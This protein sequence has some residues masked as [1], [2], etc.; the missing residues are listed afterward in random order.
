MQQATAQG[1]YMQA[2][3][4]GMMMQPP[5]GMDPNAGGYPMDAGEYHGLPAAL[6]AQYPALAT[7]NWS[8]PVMG[9]GSGM[10]DDLSGRSSFDASDYDEADD[11][12]Y[13]SGSGT[14][15]GQGG[16]NEGFGEMGYTS[17]YGGP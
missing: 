13:V 9:G 7:V 15:F 10:E 17:D 12:G 5:P 2:P 11:G 16:I 3:P 14:S 8:A 4:P 1:Q 6:L